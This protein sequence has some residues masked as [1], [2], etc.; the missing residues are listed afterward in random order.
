MKQLDYIPSL[1]YE[2]FLFILFCQEFNVTWKEISGL[3]QVLEVEL[4]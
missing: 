1:F 4:F 2:L 3:I